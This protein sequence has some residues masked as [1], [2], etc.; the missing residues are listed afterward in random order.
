[1]LKELN[2]LWVRAQHEAAAWRRWHRKLPHNRV[3]H[4]RLRDAAG[5]PVG[6]GPPRPAPEPPLSSPF[7]RVA[8]LPSGKSA[9]FL[10]DRGVEVAYRLA[11]RPCA[12]SDEVNALPMSEEVLR[13]LFEEYCR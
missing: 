1:M 11:R 3:Q 13:R 9:V 2:R 12:K 8:E 7:C 4:E 10:D 5:R 6:Y